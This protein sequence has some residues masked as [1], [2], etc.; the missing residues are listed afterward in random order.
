MTITAVNVG[1]TANDGTGDP[2]RTAFQTLN[3][4]DAELGK[5]LVTSTSDPTVN[6][7]TGDGYQIGTV[8]VNTSRG[9]AYLCRDASSGAAV[10]WPV[11][12]EEQFALATN[13]YYAPYR[14]AGFAQSGS[15][16]TGS[17]RLHPFTV[18]RRQKISHLG[19]LGHTA[20]AAR[21]MKIGLWRL[22]G[23]RPTGNPVAQVTLSAAAQNPIGTLTG[24]S[25]YVLEPGLYFAGESRDG[26]INCTSNV[27]DSAYLIGADADTSIVYTAFAA[28]HYLTVPHTYANALPDLTSATFTEQYSVGAAAI[29]WKISDDTP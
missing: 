22:N 4:N 27:A 15:L 26:N 20:D 18:R 12:N 23:R 13:A 29:Y 7:D 1:T 3:A 19:F 21:S 24:G 25:D 5:R 10:W 8:W 2:L 16:G 9:I 11:A 14:G 17:L 28:G 6:D